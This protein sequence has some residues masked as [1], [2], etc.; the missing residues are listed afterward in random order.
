MTFGVRHDI[1]A[2][3]CAV[4]E[5]HV[6]ASRRAEYHFCALRFAPGCVSGQIIQAQVCLGFNDHPGRFAMQQNAAEQM[7]RKLNCRAFKELKTD[8]FGL[9]NESPQRPGI[10]NAFDAL[11]VGFVSKR[12][13]TLEH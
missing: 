11:G 4:D 12:Q 1:E 10:M 13:C 8:R 2:L 6:R 5:I 3:M 9:A 7:R